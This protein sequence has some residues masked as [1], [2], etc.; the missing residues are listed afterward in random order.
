MPEK[1]DPEHFKEV[2]QTFAYLHDVVERIDEK[3]AQLA[4]RVNKTVGQAAL[5]DPAICEHYTGRQQ[6][7][8][9]PKKQLG[10][11]I[12]DLLDQ[13]FTDVL[14]ISA[15]FVYVHS[16]FRAA[17][18]EI[19]SAKYSSTKFD[20]ANKRLASEKI[21]HIIFFPSKYVNTMY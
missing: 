19:Y 20:T 10:H 8:H 15:D 18:L 5:R 3:C 14:K 4:H 1:E 6:K 21:N 2:E 9:Y 13:Q 12:P 7:H 16:S 17:T 11:D